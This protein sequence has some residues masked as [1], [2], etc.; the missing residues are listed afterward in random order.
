MAQTASVDQEGN[1]KLGPEAAAAMAKRLQQCAAMPVP[2]T[3]NTVDLTANDASTEL[4]ADDASV[5][6]DGR[7]ADY[8]QSI[9][10][11]QHPTGAKRRS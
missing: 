11:Q 1:V 9:R 3:P 6:S 8:F 10:E 5:M 4:G 7:M 2:T